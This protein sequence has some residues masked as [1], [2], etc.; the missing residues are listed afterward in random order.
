M[1]RHLRFF[2]T[3]AKDKDINMA[4]VVPVTKSLPCWRD[5]FIHIYVV[6]DAAFLEFDSYAY[7]HGLKLLKLPLFP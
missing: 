2:F 1:T 4:G 5:T 3:T 7:L 6:E